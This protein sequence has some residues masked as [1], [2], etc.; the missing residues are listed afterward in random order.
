MADAYSISQSLADQDNDFLTNSRNFVWINDSNNGSYQN[1][2]VFDLASISN[3]GRYFDATQSFIVIPL[4][5]TLTSTAGDINNTSFE[6]NFALSY[7]NSFANLVHSMHVEITNNA[8]VSTMA[9]SN[10]AMTFGLLTK[11]SADDVVSLAPS[12]NFGMDTALGIKYNVAASTSGLGDTNNSIASTLF[13]P[14][15]GYG[16]TLWNQ[17]AGRFERKNQR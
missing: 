17:N 11:L 7:K 9:Y 4:V 16:Q 5:M 3:S 10:Q 15:S 8:V 12:L 6:N 13:N 14:T 1:Q 2:V